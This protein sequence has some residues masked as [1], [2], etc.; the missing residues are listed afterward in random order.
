MKIDIDLVTESPP[1]VDKAPEENTVDLVSSS[2]IHN[3]D[4]D[5]VDAVLHEHMVPFKIS[6]SSS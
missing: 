1:T 4:E 2:G 5:S 3:N 6:S